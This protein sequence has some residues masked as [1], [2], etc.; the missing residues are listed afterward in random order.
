[1]TSSVSI[2]VFTKARKPLALIVLIS[3]FAVWTGPVTAEPPPWAPAHGY[4]AKH[5][6]KHWPKSYATYQRRPVLEL[7]RCNRDVLGGILGGGAGAAIG[8]TL[9]HGDGRAAAIVGGAI[10][11]VLVGGAVGHYMDSVDQNCVGQTLERTP[12]GQT[13]AWRND[14]SGEV[15][16]VTPS[17]TFQRQDGHTCR[18]YTTEALIDG[19]QQ[20][21][22]GTAC[23]QPDGAWKLGG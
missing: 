1:M 23:R 12:N 18:H 19:Q 3:L 14:E 6:T 5:K 15:Y 22:S 21:I 17:D 11:G 16:R 2:P 8:S 20:Q 10:I 7:G 4:R 13:I 9:D